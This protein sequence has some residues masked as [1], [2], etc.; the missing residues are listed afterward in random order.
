VREPP[1]IARSLP[2][3][4]TATAARAVASAEARDGE[5]RA[6]WILA[7]DAAVLGLLYW[8]RPARFPRPWS[9]WHA[10]RRRPC[11]DRAGSVTVLG[12]GRKMR[13]V[14]VIAPVRA[15]VDA[16]LDICPY[17][18][19]P[20]GRSSWARE[21]EP[22]RRASSSWPWSA[23]AARWACR[24]PPPRTPCA[25][26]SPPICWRGA[27]SL[28]TIQELL[29]PFV[30]GDDADHPAAV[31]STRLLDAWRSAPGAEG[32]SNR[33][34]LPRRAIR[35]SARNFRNSGPLPPMKPASTS[36]GTDL[37][38]QRIG[39]AHG[40][41]RGR[42]R[43]GC[44]AS[45]TRGMEGGLSLAGLEQEGG[46]AEAQDLCAE[47]GRPARNPLLLREK[48]EGSPA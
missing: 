40:P 1:E 29:G 48:P 6:P 21:A 45:R 22:S 42:A 44:R 30:A 24:T 17:K 23:C 19:A 37:R 18:V 20:M 10:G 3:P 43:R 9:D 12:K 14:P 27:G 47:K 38:L 5:A 26:P 13:T 28:R 4:L 32:A 11:G 39:P 7:R 46:E 34:A 33:A 35:H 25:T 31:H 36:I 2:K 16:Y 8:A 15:A 41:R